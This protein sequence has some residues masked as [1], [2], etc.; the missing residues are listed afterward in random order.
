[1]NASPARRLLADV[2]EME[3]LTAVQARSS[4]KA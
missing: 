2:Q 1:M 3:M 4:A